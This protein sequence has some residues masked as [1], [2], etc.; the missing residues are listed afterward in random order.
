MG[1]PGSRL[2]NSVSPDLSKAPV[3][4]CPDPAFAAVTTI[5]SFAAWR[6]AQAASAS[7]SAATEIFVEM[8]IGWSLPWCD[9]GEHTIPALNAD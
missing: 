3:P 6:V 1:G 7:E 5:S 4:V 8:R 2:A 9:K